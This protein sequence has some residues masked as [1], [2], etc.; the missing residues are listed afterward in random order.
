MKRLHRAWA[1][2]LGCTFMLLICGGLGI[3]AFSVSQPY[4][5]AQNGF[6]NT[7]TSMITTVRDDRA[8]LCH[9]QTKRAVLEFGSLY[10][11][12]VTQ[13][14]VKKLQKRLSEEH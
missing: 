3:N 9:C 1:V 7:Q 4:I 6:T 14:D 10:L 8:V 5:L 11:F 2:C 12:L 13:L